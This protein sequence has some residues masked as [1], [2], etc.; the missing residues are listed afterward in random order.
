MQVSVD[1][2]D[3]QLA[4]WLTGVPNYLDRAR[5]TT[6]NLIAVGI[7]PRPSS[8]SLP[9]TTAKSRKRLSRTLHDLGVRRFQLVSTAAAS[10]AI[11]TICC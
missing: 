1:D 5:S 8:A 2:A 10:I 3:N 9:H 11:P 6:A 7:D 4:S